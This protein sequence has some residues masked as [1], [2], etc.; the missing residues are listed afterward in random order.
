MY[1]SIWKVYMYDIR[2]YTTFPH[3]TILLYLWRHPFRSLLPKASI[4]R[5]PKV[6]SARKVLR[7]VGSHSSMAIRPTQFT[8]SEK[9]PLRNE[10][11]GQCSIPNGFEKSGSSQFRY[12]HISGTIGNV[13]LARKPDAVLN[14]EGIRR[15]LWRHHPG[16]RTRQL[17]EEFTDKRRP[18][19]SIYIYLQV[20]WNLY[21][22]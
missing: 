6:T 11:F 7:M 1:R 20:L 13:S 14:H 18:S 17:K 15:A 16:C 4:S 22:R 5:N 19:L 3:T 2:H 10:C 21:Y 9:L 12:E 8:M